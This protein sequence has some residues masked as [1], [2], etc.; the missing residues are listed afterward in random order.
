VNDTE[1]QWNRALVTIYKT[2]KRELG[3]P[4]NRFLH[5]LGDHGGVVTAKQ[6]LWSD[7]PSDG[8]TFLGE[9]RRLELTVEATYCWTSSPA[10]SAT[11]IGN[12]PWIASKGTDGRTI[13]AV[14]QV[15]ND[16]C[17]RA[18]PMRSCVAL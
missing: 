2:A 7:K 15:G 13:K 3:Y 9:H 17:L 11:K 4:A 6:L 12:V 1:R 10:S 16:L 8:F 18:G 14:G 5:M